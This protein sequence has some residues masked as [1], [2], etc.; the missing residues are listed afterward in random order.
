MAPEQQDRNIGLC[1]RELKAA[2][3]HHRDL[4][5][6]GNDSSRRPIA[7]RILDDGKE[8]CFIARLRVNDIGRCKPGLFQSRRVEVAAAAHPQHRRLERA[9]FARSDP[10]KEQGRGGIVDQRARARGRLVQSAGT[11]PP[12]AQATVQSLGGKRHRA[13]FRKRRRQSPQMLDCRQG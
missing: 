8:R 3:R 2:G 9:G 5:G 12:A 11:Q 1:R 4:A 13:K 7:D 6:L 10:C